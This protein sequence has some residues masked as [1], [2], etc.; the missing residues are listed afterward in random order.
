MGYGEKVDGVIGQLS[1]FLHL[2]SAKTNTLADIERYC[3]LTPEQL[4][5]APP[6]LPE[7]S[8]KRTLV[9]RALKSSTLSWNSTHEVLCSNYRQ[10][11]VGPYK[12]NLRAQA[13]WIRPEK[14]RRDTCF[15]YVHG[16]LEP[17]SWVEEATLFRKWS[18]DLDVDL[19]HVSLPFHG[20]RMPRSSLFSGEFFWTADLVRTMEAVRQA[21]HDVRSM[22]MWLR[23]QGYERVGVGG[24]SLGGSLTM[25]TACLEPAPDFVV[26]IVSHLQLGEAVESA[27][28]LFRMREDLE[29]WGVGPEARR[30]LFDRLGL[31][32]IEPVLAPDK[33]LWIQAREDAYIDAKLAEKQWS[34]WGEPEILWIEG[35][36]MTFPMHIGEITER[37]A[38]HIEGL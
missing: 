6:K 35:G 21:V 14:K 2:R 3:D 18:K 1:R 30:E 12:K 26:P 10:R 19:A 13:R 9:D 32:D 17:G 24:I 20:A 22:V 11:H 37:I 15:I 4:F 36:H 34:A 38:Q 27:A 7:V 29:K 16:W 33:Q 5:P 25:L 23:E 31:A 28:I 8:T